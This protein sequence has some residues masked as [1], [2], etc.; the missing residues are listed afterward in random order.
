MSKL[1][2]LIN[3][4]QKKIEEAKNRFQPDSPKPGANRYRILPSWR[5]EDD[6]FWH[7]YGVHY[8]WYDAP[9]FKLADADK[10]AV[11]T[12]PKATHDAH[13]PICDV[14][15]K[16]RHLDSP[17]ELIAQFNS[18]KRVLINVLDVRGD[19]P[20]EPK[21]LSI[22]QSA[23]TG[24]LNMYSEGWTDILKLENGRDIIIKRSGQGMQTKYDVTPAQDI[25]TVNPKILEKLPN[26]DEKVKT[27]ADIT[28]AMEV[29][30]IVT[31]AISPSATKKPALTDVP[32]ERP[33]LP[34]QS[35]PVPDDPPLETVAPK[36]APTPQPA[37]VT[38]GSVNIEEIDG[39]MTDEQLQAFIADI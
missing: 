22:P 33:V 15:N 28:K 9:T 8:V 12:C 1:L 24:I 27:S 17:N 18:A 32:K 35:A 20:N 2:A 25:S 3:Q 34:A 13:C 39:D 19:D 16:N 30:G 29:V 23:F 5:G 7:D 37:P 21:V 31:G 14:V 36:P 26:L 10:K 38:A 4:K 11:F 6:E